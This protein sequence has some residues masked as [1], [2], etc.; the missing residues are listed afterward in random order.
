MKDHLMRSLAMLHRR[1]EDEPACVVLW[2]VLYMVG[3][4]NHACIL[5]LWCIPIYFPS[6]SI[7]AG[8]NPCHSL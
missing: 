1:R 6:V 7:W 5:S 2:V 8:Y 3:D 4:S